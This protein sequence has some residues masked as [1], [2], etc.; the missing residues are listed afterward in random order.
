[1]NEQS[2]P[3]AEFLGLDREHVELDDGTRG[4]IRHLFD[5]EHVLA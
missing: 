4:A 2:K 1:M 5:R 3:S